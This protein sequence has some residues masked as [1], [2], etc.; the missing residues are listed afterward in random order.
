[1]AHHRETRRRVIE[2]R[3]RWHLT[4]SFLPRKLAL[5]V[6]QRI[7]DNPDGTRDDPHPLRELGPS[8]VSTF[9]TQR[10]ISPLDLARLAV[11]FAT[12]S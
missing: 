1:V 9:V 12:A 5:A 2:I 8:G 7:R 10:R 11:T 3:N 4:A 6:R